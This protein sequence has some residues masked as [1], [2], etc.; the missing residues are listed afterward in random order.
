MEIE[1]K[2]YWHICMASAWCAGVSLRR[3]NVISSGSSIQP[4]MFGLELEWTVRVRG[5]RRVRS[6]L[7]SPTPLLIFDRRP[8]PAFRCHKIKDGG[9]NFC[10]ENTKHSPA[11]IT[12]D[13]QASMTFDWLV[14]IH[15]YATISFPLLNKGK[16]RRHLIITQ[17]WQV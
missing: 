8:S 12:P 1:V 14:V 16:E 13:L 7:N 15:S 9:H 17:R 5:G 4:A 10:K 2:K 11:K 6:N 3:T